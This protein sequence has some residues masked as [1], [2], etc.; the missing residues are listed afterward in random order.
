MFLGFQSIDSSMAGNCCNYF[1]LIL[2]YCEWCL[3]CSRNFFFLRNDSLTWQPFHWCNINCKG[4]CQFT[5]GMTDCLQHFTT[6]VMPWLQIPQWPDEK[7]TSCEWQQRPTTRPTTWSIL[8]EPTIR[9]GYCCESEWVIGMSQLQLKLQ[10]TLAFS[11]M[12]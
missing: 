1:N 8:Q 3:F 5:K 11:L 10:F 9:H 12:L 2:I 7:A 6:E 4:I